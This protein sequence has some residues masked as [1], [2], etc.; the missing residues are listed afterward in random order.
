MIEHSDLTTKVYQWLKERIMHHA[1]L[2]GDKLD[3]QQLADALGV[4]RTPVKDAI[5]RL[6]AE[7]LVILRSRRGTYVATLTPAALRD[8]FGTRMMIECWVVQHATPV[9]ME[10]AASGMQALF[11]R[12]AAV[13]TGANPTNFDYSAY[14]AL[15]LDLHA[16]L[17]GLTENAV[18]L[19]LHHAVV[20]RM[21]AGRIYYPGEDEVLRRSHSALDEHAAIV[22]A[23]ADRDRD[24]LLAAVR[25][26]ITASME[27]TAWLLDRAAH[28]NG[29]RPAPAIDAL[30]S[31]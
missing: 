13:I 21:S 9:A 7:G 22:R 11:A 26:H 31:R 19:E 23:L 12:S 17:V 14:F 8:L 18:L 3:I 1:F 28:T 5:N 2:P 27:H 6:T 30:A 16:L 25:T 15:D 20:A 29:A 4:S 10:A 24:A